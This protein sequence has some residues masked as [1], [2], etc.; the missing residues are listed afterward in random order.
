MAGEEVPQ[1][2]RRLWGKHTLLGQ[3]RHRA[4]LF[5]EPSRIMTVLTASHASFYEPLLLSDTSYEQVA[6]Q[7]LDR[8]TAPAILYAL[9]RLKKKLQ[10]IPRSRSFP[11]ITP[12][13]TTGSSYITSR[14]HFM[15]SM[16]GPRK[17]YC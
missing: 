2:F 17:P 11:P 3:T 5:A 13:R 6:V 9:M 1:Q 14:Q 15:R 12:S 10:W 7:P 4:A 8:G 16:P